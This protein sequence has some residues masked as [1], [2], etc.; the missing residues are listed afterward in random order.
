MNDEKKVPE[1]CPEC[2][3]KMDYPDIEG[4]DVIIRCSNPD[5]TFEIIRKG[6]A[7]NEE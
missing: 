5:C 3:E 4:D 6:E 7:K 1:I 2:G